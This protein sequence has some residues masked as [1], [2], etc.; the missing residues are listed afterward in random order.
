MLSTQL[1]DAG[2]IFSYSNGDH[3]FLGFR[4][5]TPHFLLSLT[6]NSLNIL[7]PMTSLFNAIHKDP[8]FK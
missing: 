1:W 8:L 4:D 3:I 2:H 6:R 7:V 5:H